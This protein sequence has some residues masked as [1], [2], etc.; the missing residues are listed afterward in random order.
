[1]SEHN[2]FNPN[3]IENYKP[4]L[5]SWEEFAYLINIRPLMTTGRVNIC[6]P[7]RMKMG[8][9]RTNWTLD[10]NTIPPT[11]LRTCIEGHLVNLVD[12]SRATE[13][14]NAFCKELEDEYQL[15][16]DAH[17]FSCR[18]TNI[19][20]PFGAHFDQSHNVIVQCEGETNF[21]VW[22]AVTDLDQQPN[23]MVI[24]EDPILDVLMKP[25]DAIWI[26]VLH[27]HLATSK[28]PRLSVSF[29]IWPHSSLEQASEDRTWVDFN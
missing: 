13:K 17:I 4:N 22:D 20:H 9:K 21:K 7:Y 8:W 14:I 5:F 25:G 1:M 10:P 26:P 12:M 15:Q 24:E 19:P 11:L 29:P 18:N 3:Y 6:V 27:P 28:T 23:Q 2:I 16:T